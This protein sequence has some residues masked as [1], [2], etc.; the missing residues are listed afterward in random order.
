MEI[1]YLLCEMGSNPE[2]YKIGITDGDPRKRIKQLQT[3]C[4]N[5]IVLINTFE[6]KF[7]R[8][9]ESSLHR[10]YSQYSTSGGKEW[11]ELPSDEVL[12][13]IQKCTKY[14]TIFKG[15]EESENPFFK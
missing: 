15:L 7:Y 2:R 4:S 9:I 6:S 13:F 10:E 5:E 3:G 8:K 11:F 1:I 12:Q 14:H